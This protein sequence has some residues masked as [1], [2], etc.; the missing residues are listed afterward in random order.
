[1]RRPATTCI[2]L[3][4]VLAAPAAAAEE[5]GAAW[6][7]L[8]KKYG[9]GT[10]TA[11]YA[12]E[13]GQIP[14]G[15]QEEAGGTVRPKHL[16]WP[17]KGGRFGRGV[18]AGSDGHHQGLDIVAPTGT[19]IKA[20]WYGIVIYASERKG[21]GKTVQIVHPGG[22]VTLYAH[23]SALKVKPGMKVKTGQKIALVGSTG[24]SRGPHL[25]WELRVK[26]VITDPS[27]FI[28]PS[29]PHPPH[30]GPMPWQGYTV[31][32][33]DT[34]AAIAKKKGV[35]L[36]ELLS[37]NQIKESS[38]LQAGWKIALPIK[39]KGKA[40]TKDMYVVQKGDSLGSIAVLY[41]VKIADLMALNSISDPDKVS[42][43]QKIKLPAGAYSGAAIA[44]KQ[45]DKQE[46]EGKEWIWHE[47]EE[48][49]SLFTIA[50]KYK[51]SITAISN[52]NGIKDKDSLQ[53]GQKL[54]VPKPSKKKKGEKVAEE[55]PA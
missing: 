26:G 43:G 45:A 20:A 17:V 16:V 50:K 29:I 15:L 10:W 25:H 19:T 41:D 52:L 14:A 1:M 9:L 5:E 22:W 40:F 7:Q 2:L 31:K 4:A 38:P 8:A 21:Y 46:G 36:E 12:A 49:E 13:Q 48:G 6:Q 18:G 54:K 3:V 53:I 34:P 39:V 28:N 32:K 33:G 47:V 24:I 11:V 23:C 30:V 42:P 35:G 51:T 55:P 44:K 27:P 37:L